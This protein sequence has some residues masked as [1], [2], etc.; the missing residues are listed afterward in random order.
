[1]TSKE[2]A[3]RFMAFSLSVYRLEKQ[4]IKTFSGRHVYRQL[5]RSATSCGANYQE[6]IGAESKRDFAHKL[7][8]VLKEIR[9]VDFWIG[10]MQHS[11]MV[12]SDDANLLVLKKESDELISIVTKTLITLKKN[13]NKTK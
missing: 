3:D 13:M 12:N 2:L 5:F 4:M 10:F 7:Q 8:I 6:A 11:K 9:E 1:M